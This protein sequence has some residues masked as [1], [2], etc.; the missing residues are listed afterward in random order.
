MSSRMQYDGNDGSGGG[1]GGEHQGQPVQQGQ[2][3]QLDQPDGIGKLCCCLQDGPQ[4]NDPRG[5]RQNQF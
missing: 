2:Q 1:G 3:V 5:D 4:E